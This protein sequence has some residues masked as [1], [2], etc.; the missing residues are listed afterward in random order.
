MATDWTKSSGS[1]TTWSKGSL[2]TTGFNGREVTN[3][4]AI[5]DDEDYILDDP[6]LTLDDL[7]ISSQFASSTNW[8]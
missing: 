8:S 3:L 6:V 1:Q 2:S 5:L 7:K 4:G